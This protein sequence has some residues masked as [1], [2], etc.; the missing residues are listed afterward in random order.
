VLLVR[1]DALSPRHKNGIL[2][3]RRT[4]VVLLA[5]SKVPSGGDDEECEEDDR[6]VVHELGGD[7]DGGW[8]AEEGDGESRPAYI[9]LVN[10]K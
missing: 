2:V 4:L 8:H 7:G 6:R 3:R 1:H 9:A 5:P 10:T